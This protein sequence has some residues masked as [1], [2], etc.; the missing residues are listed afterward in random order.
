LV[1]REFFPGVLRM[2]DF[3]NPDLHIP[4]RSETTV[5]QQALFFLNHPLW[6]EFAEQLATCDSSDGGPEERVAELYRRV[7]QREPSTFEVRMALDL[8]ESAAQDPPNPE[9]E[10]MRDWQYGYGP[11]DEKT[12][13]VKSFAAL[14]HF[15]GSAWQGGA[16]WPDDALGWVRLTAEG[17]HAGNDLEHAAIRR[18]TAP[19]SMRISIQGSLEHHNEA[20]DGVRGRIVYN[21][22]RVIAEAVIHKRSAEMAAPTFEVHAGDTL[23]FVVDRYE[24]LNSDDFLWTPHIVEEGGRRTVWK[25]KE[26]FGTMRRTPLDPWQQLAQVLLMANEFMFVD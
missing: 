10:T 25:A 7:Y 12:G 23:D 8:V 19:R 11:W 1:D 5:P 13:A 15:T 21:S 17:G 4:Q 9:P 3:A 20:G 2:F 16:K 14:P 22:Q 6:I 24:N 18:W 26:D